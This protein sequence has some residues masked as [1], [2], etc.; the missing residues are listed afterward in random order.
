MLNQSNI[1][2]VRYYEDRTNNMKGQPYRYNSGQAAL[3]SVFFVMMIML[4]AVFGIS[5][6]AINEHSVANQNFTSSKSFYAAEAGIEDAVY[7][8]KNSNS[9]K[10]GSSFAITLNGATANISITDVPP[11]QKKIE[12]IGDAS[13]ATRIIDAYL[14]IQPGASFQF[15]L[16]AGS[17]GIE[18]GN[19]SLID[20]NVYSNGSVE[21][22]NGSVIK[23]DARVAGTQIVVDSLANYEP[24]SP[25]D[26]QVGHANPVIDV[27]RSFVLSQTGPVSV[28]GMLLKKVGS[29]T[30]KT[31]YIMSS[32]ANGYPSG[33][34]LA[35]GTL[36]SSLVSNSL[37]WVTVAL[38]SNPSL[39]VGTKYWIVFDSV[40]DANDYYDW[41]IGSSGGNTSAYSLNRTNGSNSWTTIN[42]DLAYRVYLGTGGI[43]HLQNM[44][45]QGNAYANT[46]INSQICGDAYYQNIDQS[47]YDFL[48][49]SS[50]PGGICPQLP[51]AGRAHP[52]SADLPYQPLPISDAWIVEKEQDA[53]ARGAAFT[54]ALT[55]T[56]PYTIP[57]GAIIGPGKINC[58]VRTL[59]N[60]NITVKSPLWIVGD[61]NFANSNVVVLDP[62][63]PDGQDGVVIMDSPTSSTTKGILSPGNSFVG[64]GARTYSGGICDTT[65]NSSYLLFISMYSGPGSAIDLANSAVGAILY[66]PH[67]TFSV[68]NGIQVNAVAANKIDIANNASIKY[69]TGLVN[70]LFSPPQSGG[71]ADWGIASW[72]EVAP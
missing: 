55:C 57:N 4:S 20:G 41:G 17:G 35:S 28:V 2:G 29:P 64:C 42:G 48:M 13:D 63:T 43:N 9:K 53:E 69:E 49:T 24:A 37:S 21:G 6:L 45:V 44:V 14:S 56:S 32:A 70:L 46:I 16:Q 72:Q 50:N 12:A 36:N 62:S 68:G 1:M 18:M 25:T 7:R 27:A 26:Y 38:S 66:A 71:A 8:Y 51:P 39:A 3:I 23:Y 54:G 30:N 58:S 31:V 61:A 34:I 65:L 22:S 59:N 40:L 47:S 5:S 19:T 10:I 52:N 15:A 60:T 11:S 67:G 33:T